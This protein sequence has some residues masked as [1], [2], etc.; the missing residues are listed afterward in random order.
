M[1]R[2]VRLISILSCVAVLLCVGPAHTWAS[3]VAVLENIIDDRQNQLTKQDMVT[4]AIQ[5]LGDLGNIDGATVL[6]DNILYPQMNLT[7]EEMR[8]GKGTFI[9]VDGGH[10]SVGPDGRSA[11][12]SNAFPAVRA[13]VEIGRDVIPLVL[14]RLT[15]TDGI[16]SRNAYLDVLIE[17]MDKAEV[18]ALLNDELS[19]AQSEKAEQRLYKS[20]DMLPC[21]RPMMELYKPGKASAASIKPDSGI[22]AGRRKLLEM[23]KL[24]IPPLIVVNDL[25]LS[26]GSMI[27]GGVTLA[28]AKELAGLLNVASK[29]DGDKLVL[30]TTGANPKTLVLYRDAKHALAG[31][32]RISLPAATVVRDKELFVP[33]RAVAEYFGAKVKWDPLPRVAWVR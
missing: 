23:A 17:L 4:A 10:W 9:H 8:S 2:L 7:L 5:A 6:L 30:F 14:Q 19:F 31:N 21:L 18:E 12:T 15:E 11:T 28:P 3:N 29:Q 25:A 22:V 1:H 27:V 20:V 32:R 24:D 16:L 33:L 26:R 13:L